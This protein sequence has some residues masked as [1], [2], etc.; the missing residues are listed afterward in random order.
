MLFSY[1]IIFWEFGLS[2]WSSMML[3]INKVGLYSTYD[4]AIQ[5]CHVGPPIPRQRDNCHGVLGPHCLH[6]KG[7]L[8]LRVSQ[9]MSCPSPEIGASKVGVLTC[10]S[11]SYSYVNGISKR[12]SISML[13]HV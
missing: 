10:K 2:V 8:R 5:L 11:C 9:S 4:L 12:Y 6:G 7:C 13:Y 3:Y 1:H